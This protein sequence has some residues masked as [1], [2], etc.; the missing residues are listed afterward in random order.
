MAS[1]RSFEKLTC[2][3]RI[4]FGKTK[5]MAK[6]LGHNAEEEHLPNV[7]RLTSHLRGSVGLLFTSQAPDDILGF[8]SEYIQTDFARAG[9]LAPRSFT[10]PEGVVYSRAGEVPC[11]D[12]VPVSHSLEPTL[13][14]WGMPSKLV[15]GRVMLDDPYDVCKE[16]REL[17]SHQ[18]ALL[19]LFGIP[20]ADFRVQIK[21]LV[22][23]RI[24]YR[25]TA[26]CRCAATTT[27]HLKK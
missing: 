13:R 16:G 11:E 6:A 10:V 23:G 21:A 17:N 12:D 26:D 18:T 25:T 19:K 9:I 3:G 24:Y 1:A 5:L 22:S 8:F 2:A 7:S 14:K 15:K 4:L 27:R 20:M